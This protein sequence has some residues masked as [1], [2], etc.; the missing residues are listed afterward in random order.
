MQDDK[1]AIGEVREK[2]VYIYRCPK[3]GKFYKENC[4]NDGLLCSCGTVATM[5]TPDYTIKHYKKV[6]GASNFMT[7]LFTLLLPVITMCLFMFIGEQK[8]SDINLKL[9]IL[10]FVIIG[11]II[12]KSKRLLERTIKNTTITTAIENLM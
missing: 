10:T 12:L 9:P 2:I 8:D 4:R 6:R 3:C 7:I 5:A 11:A 1:V